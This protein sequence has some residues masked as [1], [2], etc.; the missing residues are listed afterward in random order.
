[1]SLSAFSQLARE[2]SSAWRPPPKL[3]LSEWADRYFVLS[4]ESA[5]EAGRWKTLPYQREIMDSLTDP[6]VTFVA[7]MKSARVGYTKMIN[8][9]VGY[10]I[11]Q[12]PCPILVV[13]PTVEDAKGY[14]K[15]EIAPLLRDTPALSKII[16]EDA[17]ES[18]GPRDSG[19]TILHKK[20]PGGVL[21]MVGANSG[22]GFRRVSRKAVLFDEVD[23]YPPSAGS[24]GDQIKLGVRRT[25]Y[26]WDRKVVMGSTPLIAGASRI[27]RAFEEGDQRR[28]FVPCPSCGH[29]A[30]LVFSGDKGHSMKWP[31]GKPEEAFVQCQAN[32]CVIEHRHKR[33]MVERGEWRAQ[34]P[35]SEKR[36]YHIWAAYSY[37]PNATWGQIAEE[38][39]EAKKNPETLR[40]FVNTVLGETWREKGEAPEWE[41]LYERREEY[42]RGVVPRGVAMLTAG[43]DV[44][45]DRLVWEVVGW[46]E[47]RSSW[48]V[49]CGVLAGAPAEDAVWKRLEAEVLNRSWPGEDGV[50]RRIVQLAVDSGDQTQAVYHWARGHI[51]RVI[52]CKGS[53]TARVLIGAPTP[54]EVKWNGKRISHGCKVWP[55]GVDAA[56]SE[57]Y[58]WLRM[59]APLDG[60]EWPAGWCHFPDGYEA[61]F[62]KQ[63]TAEQLVTVVDRRGFSKREWQVIPG[64]E[65]HWLDC[66]VY[67]RAA[68]AAA[69]LDRIAAGAARRRRTAPPQKPQAA[70]AGVPPAALAPRQA[71]PPAPL[72]VAPRPARAGWLHGGSPRGGGWLGRR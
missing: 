19:N 2:S 14:S 58:G 64:R 62:F 17:E 29:M 44:Q 57:L 42:E 66:R 6:S 9:F 13:Q 53:A 34:N 60:E 45:R 36:S 31:E 39:L 61:E 22:A 49:D 4:A 56:K 3:T 32:G 5:A 12:A 23:G 43:V 47:D 8:A 24:D 70:E 40:S 33:E 48:S 55:V 52:A 26:Y 59:A 18:V 30:P 46:G 38:F 71:A 72:P 28:C 35:G 65:N 54:V 20:F 7:V 50:E 51:G 67:A 63:L 69:G 16:F 11:H 27:E 1:V 41:R 15:E 68:A 21:S 10:C 37:S 25:E